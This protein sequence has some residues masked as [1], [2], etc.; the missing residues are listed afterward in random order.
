[1]VSILVF[2]AEFSQVF[3]VSEIL[4]NKILGNF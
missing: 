3:C 4:H 1:M 2:T